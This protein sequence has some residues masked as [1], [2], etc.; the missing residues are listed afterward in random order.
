[1]FG[2]INSKRARTDRRG[3]TSVS[4]HLFL[5][6]LAGLVSVGKFDRIYDTAVANGNAFHQTQWCRLGVERLPCG[7]VFP[8]PPENMKQVCL[9]FFLAVGKYIFSAPQT[10]LHFVS[11]CGTPCQNLIILAFV[12]YI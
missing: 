5:V 9:V 6:L 2:E 3:I 1:M 10:F 4:T 12:C 8:K 11:T 7:G